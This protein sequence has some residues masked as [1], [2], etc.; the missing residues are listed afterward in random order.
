MLNKI[1]SRRSSTPVTCIE[2][3]GVQNN[4]AKSIA[5][6][7]NNHFCSIGSKLVAKLKSGVAQ[8][9]QPT[10]KDVDEFHFDPIDKLFVC[11]QLSK[12]KANKA[13]GL[14]RI[15]ARLL[16]D[17]AIQITPVLTNLFNHSLLSSTFPSAW[18]SG[19]VVPLYK[20]GDRCNP[21][22]YRP[23]TVLPTVSKILEKA[24]HTQ[25]YRYLLQNKILS[26]RQFGFRPK[27]STEV[28][29]TDFTDF[30]LGNMDKGCVTG[31][32][33]LDLSKAF[34]TID[35]DSLLHKLTKVG[36]SSSIGFSLTFQTEHKSLALVTLVLRQSMYLLV[37]LE[38]VCWDHYFL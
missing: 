21:S 22:N 3:D 20:S 6:T 15:T 12:L 9:N 18:K 38:V 10:Q 16:N 29:L 32:V 35:H 13:T 5:E 4:Q 14:D 11:N 2:V 30:I 31:A 7:L 37:F 8:N 33:F 24:V 1:T 19:K 26:P 27:L 28:A 34:D 25:V 23:V 17:A 36:F